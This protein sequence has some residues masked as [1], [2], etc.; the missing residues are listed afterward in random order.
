[1]SVEGACTPL[2]LAVLKFLQTSFGLVVSD[3]ER[4]TNPFALLLHRMTALAKASDSVLCCGSWSAAVPEHPILR[5]LHRDVAAQLAD[6][7]GLSDTHHLMVCLRAD[8]NE[9]FESVILS[10]HSKHVTLE[11]VR[12]R[13][14]RSAES[15]ATTPFAAHVSHADCPP[16]AI[17]N[18]IIL[19]RLLDS[20]HAQCT[21]VMRP[22]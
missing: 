2:R 6:R 8:A 21:R 3:T 18:P 19:E 13:Q 17:D 5:D 1:M 14:D 12:A 16:F 4:S 9:C 7:L 20:I 11:S 22:L 10:E 15:A